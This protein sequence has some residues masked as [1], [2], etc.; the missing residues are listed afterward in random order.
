MTDE[1]SIQQKRPSATPYVL[2]GGLVGGLAG[3]FGLPA[4]ETTKKW[5]SDPAK[6]KSFEELV[7]ESSDNDKFEKAISE[8]TDSQ[9]TLMEK[10][11]GY[12]EAKI[13]KD[14]EDAWQ[15]EFDA[16]KADKKVALPADHALM[17]EKAQAEEAKKV[18]QEALDKKIAALEKVEADRLAK[19]CADVDPIAVKELQTKINEANKDLNQKNK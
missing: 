18:A 2:G 12:D 14:A 13:I 3:G 9:K 7:K 10:V 17:T 19:A 8:A 16:F 4:T 11:K 6:Y 5:I 15:K 1:L